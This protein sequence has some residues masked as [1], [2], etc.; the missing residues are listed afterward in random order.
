MTKKE[1][2][3]FSGHYLPGYKAGGILTAVSNLV[4]NLKDKMNLRVVTR[5]RDLGSDD[6]YSDIETDKWTNV[7]GVPVFYQSK[8]IFNFFYI[9]FL[10][11]SYKKTSFF[12]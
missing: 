6:K 2:I 12:F 3:I 8:N 5:D 11:N 1:F 4:I 7:N 9:S 10:F